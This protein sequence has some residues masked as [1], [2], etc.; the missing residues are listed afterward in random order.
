MAYFFGFKQYLISNRLYPPMGF[1]RGSVVKT[2]LANAG[3]AGSIL[4]LGRS[5]GLASGSPLQY[6]CLGNPMDRGS[7]QATVHGVAKDMT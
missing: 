3:Y 7:W 6:S 2:A 1:P 4:R 5:S